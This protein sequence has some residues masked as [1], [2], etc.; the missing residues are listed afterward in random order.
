[1][2][3]DYGNAVN[4]SW[5]QVLRQSGYKMTHDTEYLGRNDGQQLPMMSKQ[6]IYNASFSR[7]DALLFSTNT[8]VSYNGTATAYPE[9]YFC[10]TKK[11]AAAQMYD[12]NGEYYKFIEAIRHDTANGLVHGEVI[13]S[14]DSYSEKV[15]LTQ[16]LEYCK[17][18]GVEVIP[19]A[20]AYDFCFNY[21]IE[22]GNLI[23]NPAL[24]NTAKE[25][26]PDAEKVPDNPDGYI[27]DCNVIQDSDRESALITIG[28]SYYLHYG[29]PLGNIRYSAD[30]KGNGRIVIFAI[31]N[32]D[33]TDLNNDNLL[34]LDEISISKEG[35]G[36]CVSEFTVTNNEETDYEQL[37]EGLGEKI[38]G[39]KIVYSSGLQIKNITLEKVK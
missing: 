17:Q 20:A 30:V 37:C 19:K 9:S 32:S 28:E 24:R 27:G 35:Y 21:K 3:D 11:S 39:L 10:D 6:L 2:T 7:R 25:F 13:D 36:K 29:I 14:V 5:I 38:M 15:F 12:G 34:K 22:E 1:M 33:S 8:T 23:Y 26:M 31:K 4:R 16:V 18:T